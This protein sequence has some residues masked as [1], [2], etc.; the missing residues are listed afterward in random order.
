L[1]EVLA[2]VILAIGQLTDLNPRADEDIALILLTQ[3]DAYFAG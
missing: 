1:V 3:A 2:R